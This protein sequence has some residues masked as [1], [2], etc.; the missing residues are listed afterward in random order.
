MYVWLGSCTG[1][2]YGYGNLAMEMVVLVLVLVL[3]PQK[4]TIYI[5]NLP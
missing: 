4:N 2:V 5:D 3:S 1:C